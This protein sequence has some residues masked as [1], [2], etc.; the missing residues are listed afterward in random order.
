MVCATNLCTPNQPACNG[1]V[2]ATC[3][4][5]GSGYL[6]GGTSC[7]P[8]LCSGGTCMNVY[9]NETFED[10]SYARWTLGT[11]NY[12]ISASSTPGANGTTYALVMTR[13]TQGSSGDGLTY[14]FPSPVQPSTVS[15]WMKSANTVSG[16][17]YTRLV[18]GTD[19]I[20]YTN[21]V[22]GR[23]Y[24]TYNNGDFSAVSGAAADTWYH[25]ELRNIVWT[26]RTFDLYV[27]GTALATAR[28]FS[29]TSTSIGSIQLYNAAPETASYWDEI[30]VLP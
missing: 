4:A 14:T 9:L 29:G 22:S 30:E 26:S 20:F 19:V 18:N 24:A 25:V 8:N 17:A 12:T 15:Y 1:N 28:P 16:Q 10:Q 27:D 7:D 5:D 21:F 3:N 13:N 11:G 2:L 23:L 6:T